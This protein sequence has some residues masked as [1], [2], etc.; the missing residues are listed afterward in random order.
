MAIG[1]RCLET[2]PWGVNHQGAWF[3]D[4]APLRARSDEGFAM[5]ALGFRPFYLLAALFAAL[6]LPLWIVEHLGGMPSFGGY[7]GGMLWHAHEMVF[8]FAVAVI[9]GFLLT[10]VRNWTGLDT[11]SGARL[12]ALVG[13]WLAGRVLVITG[14]GTLAAV[15]DALFLPVVAFVLWTPLRRA[16]NRNQFFV[17]ILL[18]FAVLNVA[19]HVAHLRHADWPALSAIEAAVAMVVLMVTIMAGRVIP[20]FTA[21][22]ISTARVRQYP[23]LDRAAI[24]AVIL[25]MIA[26]LAGA[27]PAIVAALAFAAAFTNAA[28]LVFWDPLATL[29]SPILWILHVSYAWIPIGFTLLG[30]GILRGSE[31]PLH[32][33]HAFGVGAIGGMVIGMITRTARGHTG[34]PLRAG[35]MEVIAYVFVH[36]AALLRVFVPIIWPSAYMWSV[37][38]AAALWSMAFALYAIVYVPILTRPR[39]DGKPG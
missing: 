9:T 20:A 35:T 3:N 6:T 7:L 39:I 17:L 37:A 11:P 22:A 19:F 16:R 18:G 15:V 21:N 23:M 29:R 38:G 10:A 30:I 8:G 4:I 34:R 26:Y 27:A 36:V 1:G 28:R 32:A 33:I 14:P 24:T 12:A 5:F 25:A 2:G 31:V 13:L